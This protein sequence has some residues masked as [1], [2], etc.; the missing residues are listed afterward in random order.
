MQHLLHR[1]N[2]QVAYDGDQQAARGLQE[3]LSQL[4][5]YTLKTLLSEV[6]DDFCPE[7]QHWQLD[8]L[9]LELGH[10]DEEELE[11]ELPKRIKEALFI[12]LQRQLG[13]RLQER[14]NEAP[15]RID[16]DERKE[17]EAL[18]PGGS[19]MLGEAEAALAFLQHYLQTGSS[20]WWVRGSRTHKEVMTD[21]LADNPAKIATLVRRVGRLE[22]PRKRITWQYYPSPLDTLVK[23]LEPH[24]FDTIDDY[25]QRL[26]AL[27]KQHSG[28]QQLVLARRSWYWI[29]THLLTE[30]GSLFNTTSFVLST[31][32]QMAHHYRLDLELLLQQM[33]Q[34][35]QEV[36]LA[37]PQLPVFLQALLAAKEKLERQVT[38]QREPF[39]HWRHFAHQVTGEN[40]ERQLPLAEHFVYLV[41]E[42]TKRMASLLRRVGR[43]EV[44]H[45]KLLE[46]LSEDEKAIVVALMVPDDAAFV[47]RH[48]K[49]SQK[50]LHATSQ[51]SQKMLWKSVFEYLLPYEGALNRE[52]FVRYTLQQWGHTHQTDERQML[53]LFLTS[54]TSTGEDLAYREYL[55]VLLEKKDTP[56]EKTEAL[57][58]L[59]IYG[60]QLQH[61]LYYGPVARVK[62]TEGIDRIR[63]R[64]WLQL[65]LYRAPETLIRLLHEGWRESQH[66]TQWLDHLLGVLHTADAHVLVRTLAPEAEWLP[67]LI[68]LD[69]ERG[70]LTGLRWLLQNRRRN[71]RSIEQA[72]K[73][74]V[75]ASPSLRRTYARVVYE[76]EQGTK[77]TQSLSAGLYQAIKHWQQQETKT[78]EHTS[79]SEDPLTRLLTSLKEKRPVSLVLPLLDELL[80]D[81]GPDLLHALRE[82]PQGHS[83]SLALLQLRDKSEVLKDWLETSWPL[84]QASPTKLVAIV[85]KRAQESRHWQGSRTLLERRLLE[86]LWLC[87]FTH[88]GTHTTKPERWLPQLLTLWAET[89]G[90]QDAQLSELIHTEPDPASQIFASTKGSYER[91]PRHPKDVEQAAQGSAQR[92]PK[93]QKE[94][95]EATQVWQI[96]ASGQYLQKPVMARVLGHWLRYGQPPLWWHS[97]PRL[98]LEGLLSDVL[99]FSPELLVT[100]LRQAHTQ[101]VTLRVVVQ[102]LSSSIDFQALLQLIGQQSPG[103][104]Q[105]LSSLATLASVFV[106]GWLDHIPSL[107]REVPY[108]LLWQ[109]L[110]QQWLS[111]AHDKLT[112]RASIREVYQELLI[113]YPQ[114]REPLKEVFTA[115][116]ADALSE[117]QPAANVLKAQLEQL[118]GAKAALTGDLTTTQELLLPEG[119]SLPIKNAGLVL[120][121][122]F[123][124]MYFER[125]SLL[126]EGSFVDEQAQTEATHWLQLLV[127][128][129][130]ETDEVHLVLNK[131]LCGLPLYAPVPRGIQAPE[132]EHI[133]LA[134]GLI[135]AVIQHWS[136][137]GTSSIEGFRGNWLVRD[138]L[139]QET[140]E[141]WTLIVEKRPYDLLLDRLPFG[142][143]MV[144]LPWMSK[145]LYVTWPT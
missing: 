132:E 81:T 121:Q 29:L 92:H 118:Q 38:Q 102:R 126:E 64:E 32:S 16:G 78:K 30:R 21:A 70:W 107:R 112:K 52:H 1:L 31:L 109:H 46:A 99:T 36:S 130:H 41:R 40:T 12:E 69:I 96:D 90:V 100:V 137:I 76:F 37:H 97:S 86:Q 120:L 25:A 14:A 67:T 47:L 89:V 138:G 117:P 19:Q 6:L 116:F 54:R 85:A 57:S 26:V 129:Q 123:I 58:L 110:L 24:H 33:L 105:R 15:T 53:D 9:T 5:R 119:T 11:T 60:Q 20:P 48:I 108:L 82:H 28:D 10:I 27:Q 101:P 63:P 72:L 144:R 83:L 122:H 87:W 103:L 7:E 124:K 34:A 45:S 61:F 136:A 93:G 65:L 39:D 2:W 104:R 94:A 84:R 42:D 44:A 73:A 49:Y 66:R 50:A 143:G 18:P 71:Q 128:G 51:S 43:R 17:L 139:L 135:K 22:E 23:V 95:S 13:E 56:K 133:N 145:A 140:E 125:L 4:T 59:E 134:E 115:T 141:C 106:S 62:H 91:A 114:E 98:S 68:Q 111:G 88:A 77:D 75:S 131:I 142:F 74:F 55:L 127:T 79:S 35:A 113:R 80:P 3:K 8:Q